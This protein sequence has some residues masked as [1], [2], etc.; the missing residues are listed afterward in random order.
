[1]SP[2]VMRDVGPHPVVRA[3]VGLVVGL[4]AGAVVALLV[5]RERERRNRGGLSTG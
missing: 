5:P 1:M 2:S 3:V 4:A